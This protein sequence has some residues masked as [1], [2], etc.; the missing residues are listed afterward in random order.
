MPRIGCNSLRCRLVWA[1]DTDVTRRIARRRRG[2]RWAAAAAVVL[3]AACGSGS[4]TE[5]SSAEP[6]T[7]DASEDGAALDVEVAPD[8]PEAATDEPALGWTGPDGT[9]IRFADVTDEAGVAVTHQTPFDSLKS[10]AEIMG[11]AAVGDFDGDGW[12]DLFVIGG[13]VEADSLFVNNGDGTFT[14]VAAEAGLAEK[15]VGSGAT[16]G[17][18]DGDGWLDIYVTSHGTAEEGQVVGQHHLFRN[19]GDL[20]FTDVAVE[21]G[22][23]MTSREV[24]DGFGAAF[25]DIDLDGDLDL[26]VAGWVRDSRGNRLFRNDGDGTF[27]DVTDEAGIVDDGIRGFSPCIVDT[28]GDRY[29]EILLVADFATT[30]YFRNLG[31]GTFTEFEDQAGVAFDGDGMGSAIGDFN[32]DGLVDWYATGIYDDESSGRGDGNKLYLNQGDHSFVETAADSGVDDGGWAWGAVAVDLNLDGLLDIVETNG[33]RLPAYD[34]EMSKVWIQGPDAAFAEV[35]EESGLIH[36]LFGLSVIHFDYDGDGDHDIAFTAGNDEF[37]LYQTELDPQPN[38]LTV[39]LDTSANPGLAPNGF[40][41]VVRVDAGG[42]S[43]YEN[44]VGCSNYLSASELTA[45]FGLGSADTVERVVVEWPDGTT[46]ELE[47]VDANQ[48]ITVEAPAS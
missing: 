22:V 18:Y 19:N 38:W 2:C 16:V 17:D 1:K 46:T 35:A 36:D 25:G 47:A 4:S 28:D 6:D 8:E 33:W 12:Q 3:V 45:H 23:N 44:V 11:G 34:N 24:A 26:F 39:V 48:A 9:T 7:A 20:T 27:T 30:K 13:G 15:Y 10:G 14:D 43:Q 32:H 42:I 31:D 21:A 37:R 40:G 41:S 5:S 29:P